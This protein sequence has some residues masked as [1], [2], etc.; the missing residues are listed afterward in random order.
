MPPDHDP[1]RVAAVAEKT[2]TLTSGTPLA[3][4]RLVPSR[5]HHL[6]PLSCPSSSSRVGSASQDT[7]RHTWGTVRAIWSPL[8]ETDSLLRVAVPIQK[9]QE[10]FL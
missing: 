1:A 5:N 9:K 3:L 2:E 6:D 4:D 10:G 8:D 7:E